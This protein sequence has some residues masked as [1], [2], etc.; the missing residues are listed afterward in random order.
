M[1][2]LTILETTLAMSIINKNIIKHFSL[3]LPHIKTWHP[4]T[5]DQMKLLEQTSSHLN[6][7]ADKETYELHVFQLCKSSVSSV[8]A[9]ESCLQ[10][11]TLY[12]SSRSW[13][14]SCADG[15]DWNTELILIHTGP[16]TTDAVKLVWTVVLNSCKSEVAPTFPVELD[17]WLLCIFSP[18]NDDG[19][20]CCL[21]NK[22]STFLKARLICSV[23]GADGIETHFDEL[24]EFKILHWLLYVPRPRKTW[25]S[26]LCVCSQSSQVMSA[27]GTSHIVCNL[28]KLNMVFGVKFNFISVK[29]WIGRGVVFNFTLNAS[30]QMMDMESHKKQ[31]LK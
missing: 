25:L 16:V 7:T 3:F 13:L 26:V 27:A 14:T 23:P 31:V 5:K 21:V 8:T 30:I 24:S 28:V 15:P 22:W 17:G 11:L 2:Q 4:S 10:H 29:K 6:V 20:H 1:D 9:H 18:Q 19:G 12:L